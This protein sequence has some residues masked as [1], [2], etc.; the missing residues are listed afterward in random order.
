MRHL[1]ERHKGW[2]PQ[3]FLNPNL[4]VAMICRLHVFRGQLQVHLNSPVVSFELKFGVVR[5][6][7]YCFWRIVV[8]HGTALEKN[9]RSELFRKRLIDDGISCSYLSLMLDIDAIRFEASAKKPIYVRALHSPV[10]SNAAERFIY[11][12]R[13]AEFNILIAKQHW[14]IEMG[15]W[16]PCDLFE[17]RFKVAQLCH[18]F[19]IHWDFSLSNNADS[20]IVPASER[21][22][23]SRSTNNGWSSRFLR[24]AASM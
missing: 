18:T 22:V 5:G 19:W 12:M 16:L 8:L 24:Q 17:V 14:A 21:P 20:A 13:F 9:F 11:D 10:S 23:R 1:D 2:K 6:R 15:K 3:V 4:P 7:G